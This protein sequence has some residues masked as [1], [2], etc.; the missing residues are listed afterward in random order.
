MRLRR[1]RP[2]RPRPTGYVGEHADKLSH[3]RPVSAA[4]D[5]ERPTGEDRDTYY[6]R[7][8]SMVEP[9]PFP[10][11]LQPRRRRRRRA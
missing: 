11:W 8:E 5:Q 9:V 3:V 1:K 6:S 2:E 10:R 4:D 7:G